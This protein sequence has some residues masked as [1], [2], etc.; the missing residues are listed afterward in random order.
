VTKLKQKQ[1]GTKLQNLN[2][3]KT[4]KSN[5]DKTKQLKGL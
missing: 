1:V 2:S 4:E 5:C 3:D